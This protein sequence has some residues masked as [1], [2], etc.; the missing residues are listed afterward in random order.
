MA[1][2][3]GKGDLRSPP[4]SRAF[5]DGTASSTSLVTAVAQAQ[6][7]CS[8]FWCKATATTV[9]LTYKDCT[10]TS[11]DT[12]S[13]TAV[14]GDVWDLPVAAT[15]LTTNTGLLVIAYWHPSTAR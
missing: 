6:N 14:V 9:R 7:A 15:E 11:V 13:Q 5:A 10:G 4:Y 2:F 8:G 12:G 1:S 3:P